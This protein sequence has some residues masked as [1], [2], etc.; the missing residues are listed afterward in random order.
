L[1]WGSGGDRKARR[2]GGIVE[3]GESFMSLS[4][5]RSMEV[6]VPGAIME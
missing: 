2:R 6:M 3:T 4:C 1:K 5:L